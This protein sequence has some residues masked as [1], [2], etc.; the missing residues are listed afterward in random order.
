MVVIYIRFILYIKKNYDY[1]VVIFFLMFNFIMVLSYRVD[2]V[3][4]IVY[5][6]FYI[7][8]I[9]CGI[10]FFMSFFVFFIWFGEDLYK[11][12]VGKF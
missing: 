9:G 12:I 5:D 10:C 2:S 4:I 11:I 7:I 6:R 1:G 3:I 8:V